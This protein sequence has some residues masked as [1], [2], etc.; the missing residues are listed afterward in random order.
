M[1]YIGFVVQTTTMFFCGSDSTTMSPVKEHQQQQQ[2]EKE[3]QTMQGEKE[4]TLS[5]TDTVPLYNDEEDQ[6]QF[7]NDVGK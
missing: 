7:I 4:K 5:E 6:Q 1:C 3:Q 2:Q